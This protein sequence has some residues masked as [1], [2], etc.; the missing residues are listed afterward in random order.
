MAS[1]EV[2][3]TA[4]RARTEGGGGSDSENDFSKTVRLEDML[5]LKLRPSERLLKFREFKRMPEGKY[6]EASRNSVF[7]NV[8][9]T[10]QS[11]SKTLSLRKC[12]Q[13]KSV[14]YCSVECQRKHWPE[15][16]K[17]CHKHIK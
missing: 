13:C 14:R 2:E 4:K 8:C 3:P 16:K 9:A 12:S 5:E 11:L 10:C 17:E 1:V 7:S 6:A 15:H